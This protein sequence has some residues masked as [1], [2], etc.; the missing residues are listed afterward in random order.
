MISL[1]LAPAS[2][3]STLEKSEIMTNPCIE[4]LL[5]PTIYWLTHFPQAPG[6]PNVRP[7]LSEPTASTA[8]M[9][10]TMR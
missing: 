4:S 5:I 1:R 3:E 7:I 2:K 6:I 10:T 8:A 9:Q